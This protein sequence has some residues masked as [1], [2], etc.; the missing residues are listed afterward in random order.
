M[1]TAEKKKPATG[2]EILRCRRITLLTFELGPEL[3]VSSGLSQHPF[4]CSQRRIVT[5]V[6]VMAARK[7]CAPI[8]FRVLVEAGDLL[9][10]FRLGRAV[11]GFHQRKMVSAITQHMPDAITSGMSCL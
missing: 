10:H 1:F 6:L 3:F 11:A 4:A 9:I 2:S 5:D 7:P 8:S